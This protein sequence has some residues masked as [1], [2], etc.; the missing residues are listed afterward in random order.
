[1]HHILRCVPT[2]FASGDFPGP[3]SFRHQRHSHSAIFRL[4]NSGIS[5]GP[6]PSSCDRSGFFRALPEQQRSVGAPGPPILGSQFKLAR[7]AF[8][9]SL[10]Q[11]Q[12]LGWKCVWV[13]QRAHGHA[14]RRPFT[15]TGNF[16]E[17][18]CEGVAIRNSLE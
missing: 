6:W 5:G 7:R 8:A 12:I 18:R 2:N 17:P 11:N 13:S 14:L 4:F 10:A 15:D 3:A 1:M 9:K 16:L